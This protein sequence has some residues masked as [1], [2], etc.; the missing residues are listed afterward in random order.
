M[1]D[2]RISRLEEKVTELH[3]DMKWVRRYLS[4][5]DKKV[6]DLKEKADRAKGGVWLLQ[7]ALPAVVSLL[8]AYF[9]GTI[10]K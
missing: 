2:S 7:I 10:K 1:N 3:T 9:T 6:D 5:Q 8:V 4:D